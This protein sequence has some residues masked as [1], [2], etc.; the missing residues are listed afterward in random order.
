MPHTGQV[1]T[2]RIASPIPTALHYYVHSFGTNKMLDFGRTGKIEGEH[3]NTCNIPSLQ[4]DSRASTIL[5][6]SYRPTKRTTHTHMLGGATTEQPEYEQR[7]ESNQLQELVG[8]L[9]FFR[10]TSGSSVSCL[11]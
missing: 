7:S 11:A 9:A 4:I 3:A 10:S 2:I 6:G 8:N 1:P 5:A